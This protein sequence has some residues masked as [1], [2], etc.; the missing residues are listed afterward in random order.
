ML[1]TLKLS[2]ENGKNLRFTKKKFGRIDSRREGESLRE[3]GRQTDRT[4]SQRV[5][6]RER[7]MVRQT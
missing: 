3:S 7:L 5:T 2:N 6:K 4:M 1:Q